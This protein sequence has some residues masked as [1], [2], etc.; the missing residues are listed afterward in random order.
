MMKLFTVE[1]WSIVHM[2]PCAAQDLCC[3]SFSF[4][5]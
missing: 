3:I 4:S 5:K 2:G 1:G